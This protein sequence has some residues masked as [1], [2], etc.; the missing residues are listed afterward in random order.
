M[1]FPMLPDHDWWTVRGHSLH[2]LL[3][4]LVPPSYH[5][6]LRCWKVLL[7]EQRTVFSVQ[8]A[9]RILHC[10]VYRE[11]VQKKMHNVL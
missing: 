8:N 2:H 3:Q 10:S 6:H 5:W 4:P 9:V 1:N 11:N 7:S